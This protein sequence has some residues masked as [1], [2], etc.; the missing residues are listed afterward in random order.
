[1]SGIL[2]IITFIFLS[3]DAHALEGT[4]Q[5]KTISKSGK[6]AVIGHGS[7]K[8]LQ[9]ND[10][11]AFF[12]K[13]GIREKPVFTFL[14]EAKCIKTSVKDSIWYLKT[15]INLGELEGGEVVLMTKRN[16]LAGHAQSTELGKV[17]FS[18]RQ[19]IRNIHG[20]QTFPVW[21]QERYMQGR[22]IDP[23]L[24]DL[25]DE[26][27]EFAFMEADEEIDKP[28][29]DE[30]LDFE[31]EAVD[32]GDRYIEEFNK[33]SNIKL[34]KRTGKKELIR[35]KQRESE[36][37]ELLNLSKG[38]FSK[39]DKY[40]NGI[41]DLYE[42]VSVDNRDLLLDSSNI[43]SSFQQ[44]NM[45]TRGLK[46]QVLEKNKDLKKLEDPLWP[47]GLSDLE[48]RRYFLSHG[49]DEFNQRK[50]LILHHKPAHE[51]TMRL[52]FSLNRNTSDADPNYQT[53]NK[54]LYIGYEWH[55]MK[56]SHF[57]RYFSLEFGAESTSG[58]YEVGT[59]L[60]AYT[61]EFAGRM[62]LNFYLNSFPSAV[63][64]LNWYI[65]A[66]GK[67][68][69]AVVKSENLS[70]TYNYYQLTLP[71]F[72]AGVKYRFRAGDEIDILP[73]IGLGWNLATIVD[74]HS[75]YNSRELFDDIKAN[76]YAADI[77]FVLG[78][79]LYF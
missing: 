23:D 9:E 15:P 22:P 70:R 29:I 36:R 35:Q 14:S 18:E 66:G 21:L 44:Y 34:L 31:E 75:F 61:Y 40:E 64:K 73:K 4:V 27:K 19:S 76:F 49:I 55:L 5:I 1:M 26:E 10:I 71:S 54:S 69:N 51:L 3:F 13:E 38:S 8:S 56:A 16:I 33:Y 6:T 74:N 24:D 48:L 45:A 32:Q 7:I 52:A 41:I 37:A 50:E 58:Q 59:D 47:S 28:I 25:D 39:L 53:V 12:I 57:L 67:I 62:M 46:R 60:N 42:D 78:L 65:G 79:G 2:A 11:G 17:I 77:K 68:G 72:Q 43:N 20:R 63:G 30:N